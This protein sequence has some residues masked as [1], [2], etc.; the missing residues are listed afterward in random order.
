MS[1]VF[2]LKA[3]ELQTLSAAMSIHDEFLYFIEIDEENNPIRKFSVPLAEGCIVNGQIKN[4][5]LLETAFEALRKETGKINE[6]VSIG[7]PEGETIIRFPTFPEMSIEDV[8]GTIDLNFN[9]YFPYPRAEAVFDS[10]RIKTPN[11][12]RR[13]DIMVMAVAA[14]S[15]TVDRILEAARNAG[16]PPGPVEPMNFAMIRS[17]P[18]AREGMSVLADRHNI[19]TVWEGFGIFFRTGNNEGNVQDILNTMRFVETQYRNVRVQK[20]IL[21]GLDFQ[22]S[23]ESDDTGLEIVNINDEYYAAMGLAMRDGPGLPPLDLRPIEFIEL[24][25]RRY[26]FNI[27][28]LMLW[29]LIV[30]FLML[31]IGT[32]SFTYSCIQELNEKI[33]I[34][35]SSVADLTPQRDAIVRQ[36]AELERK[37]ADSEKILH[38]LQSDIPVLEV[39]KELEMN[40]GLGVKFDTADFS[41]GMLGGVVV[42]LDGKAADEKTI[43]NMIDGLRA[44]GKF[45]AIKRPVSQRDQTG[46]VIFKIIL[47]MG[48]SNDDES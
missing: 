5:T 7:L 37:N 9:E 29:G 15:Q 3:P 38:F 31:S 33:E 10:I 41:K 17:I 21:A 2:Q 16:I 45:S 25:R 46:R 8:R 43:T 26:S 42:N 48:E 40:A 35:R 6:P 36:N 4:F 44:G 24:E 19:V 12:E 39:L 47:E 30:S 20:I 18:E 27:N 14:K 13:E 22:L 28:R 11:D 1:S 34:V 23:S 32:I